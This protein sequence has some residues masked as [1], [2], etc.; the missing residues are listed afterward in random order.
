MKKTLATFTRN[1]AEN[2]SMQPAT[3][4][5]GKKCALVDLL[6]RTVEKEMAP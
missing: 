5:F 1:N 3:F 2:V 6:R 4:S